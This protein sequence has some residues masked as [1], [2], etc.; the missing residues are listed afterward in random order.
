MYFT[1][2]SITLETSCFRIILKDNLVNN[3]FSNKGI[4]DNFFILYNLTIFKTKDFSKVQLL[5]D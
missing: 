3:M 4:F 5:F 1:Y 2:R